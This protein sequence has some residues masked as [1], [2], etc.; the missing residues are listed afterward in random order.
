MKWIPRQDRLEAL[1]V[2]RGYK[3]VKRF[4]FFPKKLGTERR[5][6]EIVYIKRKVKHSYYRTFEYYYES[7]MWMSEEDYLNK[8]PHK[9]TTP[10]VN[11]AKP[12]RY[13]DKPL[14]VDNT[15]KFE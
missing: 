8:Y 15:I 2:D 7:T 9:R 14:K 6:L 1:H 11:L 13:I 5:W 3:I 12:Q 10:P 4:L